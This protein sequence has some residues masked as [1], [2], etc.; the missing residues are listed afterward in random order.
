[1]SYYSKVRIEMGE[2]AQVCGNTKIFVDGV[3]QKHVGEARLVLSANDVA[4]LE[5]DIFAKVTFDG[6]AEV[7][8]VHVCPECKA[9]LIKQAGPDACA[10]IDTTTI[11][12][13]WGRKD[14]VARPTE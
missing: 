12:D 5:L 2:G 1:M 6:E 7:R 11:S 14:I 13:T 10:V 8:H 4:K 9:E 3:E